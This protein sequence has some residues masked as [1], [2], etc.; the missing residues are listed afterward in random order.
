MR[1]ADIKKLYV[2][3]FLDDGASTISLLVDERWT[4]AEILRHIASKQ[5]I[6]LTEQHAIVEEYPELYISMSISKISFLNILLFLI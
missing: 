4:V 2:K 1:E 3:F 5:K 6:P